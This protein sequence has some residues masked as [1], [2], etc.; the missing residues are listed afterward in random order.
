MQDLTPYAH[1]PITNLPATASDIEADF[2]RELKEI[3]AESIGWTELAAGC[4]L[5]AGNEDPQT[6]DIVGI[7][8]AQM[9]GQNVL[10]LL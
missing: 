9:A 5:H 2:W 6:I 7:P 4:Y 1:M 3:Q 10:W 8:S